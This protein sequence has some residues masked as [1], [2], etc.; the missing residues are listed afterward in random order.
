MGGGKTA[1]RT[2]CK[3]LWA[4]ATPPQGLEGGGISMGTFGA[5]WATLGTS[6]TCVRDAIVEVQNTLQSPSEAT[7]VCP[8]GKTRRWSPQA[9][10]SDGQ[11]GTGSSFSSPLIP[12]ASLRSHSAWLTPWQFGLFLRLPL[13]D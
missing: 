3:T 5:L 12:Q 10:I 6:C 11:Q 1:P 9:P 4:A 8:L 2:G 7:A 13:L